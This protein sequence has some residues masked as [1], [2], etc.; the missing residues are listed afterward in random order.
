[1]AAFRPGLSYLINGL[2]FTGLVFAVLAIHADLRPEKRNDGPIWDLVVE[3]WKYTL[4][5]PRLRVL[6][7]LEAAVSIFAIH[8]IALLPALA[9]D[10]LGL[11]QRGLGL[12]Y[13]MI[14]VGA[15]TSLLLM[16][17]MSDRPIKGTVIR[18]AMLLLGSGLVALSAI[19]TPALAYAILTMLG[20]ATVAQFN[21]TNTLFQLL[22]PDYLRGRVLSMHIWALSGL[23]P[24]GA[25]A[26][27]ALAQQRGL[28]FALA[29][30]GIAVVAFALWGFLQAPVNDKHLTRGI[31]R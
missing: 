16:A 20:L 4:R 2:S 29:A 7:V 27:G 22:S 26:F 18:V 14:G 5:E 15:V 19:R 17:W 3:G 31:L 24:L 11:D 9:K 23:S 30:G 25:L 21:T 13:S 12:A 6:L 1:L 28:P 8:Y 10:Q